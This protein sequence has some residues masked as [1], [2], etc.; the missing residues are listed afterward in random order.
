M[1]WDNFNESKDLIGQIEGY[2]RRFG[3]YPESVHTDKI[4]RSRENVRYCERHGIRLPGPKLGRPRKEKKQ[5]RQDELARNAVEGK[6]GHGK[7][8]FRLGCIRGKLP[9]TSSSMIAEVVSYSFW[10]VFCLGY[11]S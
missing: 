3:Y 8:R 1:S 11:S 2:W 6:F 10:Y 5:M 7:R 4:Y 9:E